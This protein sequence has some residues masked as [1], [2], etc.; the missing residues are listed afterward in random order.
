MTSE[1]A[2]LWDMPELKN[3]EVCFTPGLFSYYENPEAV[4]V[5]SDILRA[6]TAICTAF[7][8]GVKKLIP[9]AEIQEARSY[10]EKGFMVA[11]ERDGKVL[12]FADFGN[13]PFNFTPERVSGKTIVYSTTNGTQAI[14]LARASYRVAV[15]AFINIIA[16]TE[17]LV[18]MNRDVIVLCAGWKGKFN[19]EDSLFA[20]ALS[21][22]LLDH[23]TFS[24]NCDSTH[25]AMD[26]WKV[27][28]EN[29]L[30]YV[31][32]AAQRNR[33][34]KLG[35]DDVLAYCF[36][37]NITPVIPVFQDGFLISHLEA[38]NEPSRML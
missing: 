4:V 15:G 16:L 32:K 20:G 17:W 38:G 28:S 31:E 10:K 8:N 33:L 22:R 12:D 21:H 19:L 11:A 13:S 25:A 1:P 2:Y 9:V 37:E 5:V 36:T 27:A 26:L 35:L 7:G 6:T 30:A 29:P 24:T 3:I 18:S 14:Q 23:A 34:R